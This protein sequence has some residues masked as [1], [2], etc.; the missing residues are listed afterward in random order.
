MSYLLTEI[1]SWL[2]FLF[3][4]AGPFYLILGAIGIRGFK[5]ITSYEPHG[6]FLYRMNPLIKII[7]S[8][9]VMIAATVT[10][11]WIG[12]LLTA[13]ILTTYLS[14]KNGGRKLYLGGLFALSTIIGTAWG[15]AP[16]TTAATL[17]IAFPGYHPQ[18]LWNWP[19]YFSFMGYEP[20][21][22]MQA[23]LYSLQISFRTAAIISSALLLVMTNTPSQILR[24]LHKFNI[25]DSII[26][27]LMVGM[28]SIPAI[29]GYLD[30][31]MK[32]QMMRGLGSNHSRLLKPVFMLEAGIFAIV[33]TIIHLLRGAKDTAISADTRGFRATRKRSYVDEI[34]ITRIDYYALSIMCFILIAAVVSIILGFGRTI[35][36]VA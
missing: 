12:A 19:S 31:S 14:L 7:F 23:L 30:E 15:Y 16:F 13:A 25:P 18:V 28:K 35:P 4:I 24:S 33:P 34:P 2:I 26:F 10:I 11:W 5:E 36:Y 32:I 22:T 6:T 27:T 21:L 1:I 3:G 29:F 8:F 17:S 20:Q 9:T